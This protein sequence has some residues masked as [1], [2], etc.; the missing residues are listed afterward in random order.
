MSEPESATGETSLSA[1]RAGLAHRKVFEAAVHKTRVAMAMADPNLPD[2]PLV[3]VNPAFVEQ[4][5]YEPKD[6]VGRNC[7]F[8]QG[9]DTD[10]DAVL[11]IRR[12]I[13]DREPI[14]QELYNYRRDGTGFWNALYVSPVF[15][16]LGNLIYFFSSQIDVS[17]TREAQ[18]R[19]MQRLE[20]LD[21]LATGV[22]HEFSNLM[23]VVMASIER[24]STLVPDGRLR[25]HLD[26]AERAAKRA[27]EL[28]N[29]LL[30]LARR[31][32]NDDHRVDLNLVIRS[33]QDRLEQS[34]RQ[35]AYIRLELS[36]GPLAV[37]LDPD[38]LALV[39]L[40]LVRNAADAM[41]DGGAVTLSTRLLST[42]EAVSALNGQDAVALVIA[43][44]GHGMTAGIAERATELFFT[45]KQAG[46]GTGLFRALEFAD[47][48]GGRMTIDSQPGNGTRINLVFPRVSHDF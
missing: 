44:D 29:A 46:K 43:D 1:S 20:S 2:C 47:K 39:L 28:S 13:A 48:S 5:G 22:A 8:L 37:F 32:V 11:R 19:Q 7:R 41:P 23:T 12:A 24:S 38:Q 27:G 15:D 18:R 30:A 26:R 40:S 16:E 25:Q 31:R 9:P 21:A 33:L 17:A 36:P 3:F 42:E 14:T 4:T 35:D 6:A 10:R 45:T 34:L